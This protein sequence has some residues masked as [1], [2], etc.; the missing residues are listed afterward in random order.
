M[1]SFIEAT[2][3]FRTSMPW[4]HCVRLRVVAS[5]DP[6]TMSEPQRY[7]VFETARGFVAI[8]WNGNGITSVRL[9]VGSPAAAE[10]ALFARVARAVRAAP[11]A[12]IAAVIAAVTRYFA[13]EEVD[14]S[15]VAVDLGEQDPFFARVYT[16]IRQLGWG[17][18]TTYGAIAKELGAGPEA[19]RD[20]GKAMAANP[21]PL[22]VPCHRVLAAGGKLGG[23]S[24]PGGSDTKMRML[25]LEGAAPATVPSALA[26]QATFGFATERRPLRK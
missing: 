7:E 16:R 26:A 1:R 3:H 9:P 5:A 21:V 15:G 13:G 10:R 12:E 19:A 14:F 6:R 17:E 4:R 2:S 23:F 25:E 22:I 24:A 18:T 11:P 8:A 20:V